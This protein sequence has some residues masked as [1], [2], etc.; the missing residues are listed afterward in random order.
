MKQMTFFNESNVASLHAIFLGAILLFP[1]Y[2]HVF[3]I[4]K[5]SPYPLEK[6]SATFHQSRMH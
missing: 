4:S 6:Y 3:L 5:V 2:A 1:G